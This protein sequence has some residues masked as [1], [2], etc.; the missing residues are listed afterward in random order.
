[1]RIATGL[2][3]AAIVGI[4]AVMLSE[5]AVT[6]TI[7]PAV[8]YQTIEGFG[9][10]GGYGY[11]GGGAGYDQELLD[12]MVD[13]LGISMVRTDMGETGPGVAEWSAFL[14][15][16]QA[17]GRAV[18]RPV[19]VI[20]TTWCPPP[21][22]KYNNSISGDEST[23]RLKPDMYD[24]YG[25]WVLAFQQGLRSAG[26]ETYAVS[27]QN[28]PAFNNPFWSCV[29]SPA[30]YRDMVQ[31]AGPIV[32]GGLS[33]IRLFGAEH[34][35]ESWGTFEGQLMADGE[36]K[37][38][39]GALA[40]HGYSDGVH[41]TPTSSAV[42]LWKRAST[43]C[44]SAG[45]TLWMTET[46]GYG[47]PDDWGA[48]FQLAEMMYAALKYG[49]ISAWVWW[50][51]CKGDGPTMVIMEDL[52]YSK[53]YDVCKHYY[54]YIRPGSIMIDALSDNDLLFAV[55]FVDP[56]AQALVVVLLNA[57]GTTQTVSLAGQ[58]L[59]QLRRYTTSSSQG[60]ADGGVV[61]NSS[62]SITANT[63]VTLYGTDYAPPTP[64]QRER[65]QA[66]RRPAM[67]LEQA[68]ARYTVSGRRTTAARA[69]GSLYVRALSGTNAVA[70]IAIDR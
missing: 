31:A 65:A 27:L 5:G 46:S 33:G 61:N 34:M 7:D 44:K 69:A 12:R 24:D 47:S 40:V 4:S 54:R 17:K 35:L 58:S 57:T 68:D 6:V 9:A 14:N 67:R 18:G 1:M 59:P 19:R 11:P 63:V 32:T 53:R 30:E 16:V 70:G 37:P 15:A 39:M 50:Q 25:R 43:N 10:F 38:L 22:M 41:P 42:T 3:P 13:D 26:V 20:S 52:E 60:F 45:K 23:N 8:R 64:V 28:E 56:Q 62:I 51:L 2:V 55:A 36:T 48:N 21:H 66:A 49:E 29:Y